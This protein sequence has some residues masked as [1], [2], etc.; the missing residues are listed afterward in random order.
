MPMRINQAL[1]ASVTLVPGPVGAAAPLPQCRLTTGRATYN[2]PALKIPKVSASRLRWLENFGAPK[3]C[4]RSRLHPSLARLDRDRPD[5]ARREKGQAMRYSP[6]GSALLIGA[7]TCGIESLSPA[8]ASS[9]SDWSPSSCWA[10]S[11]D[12]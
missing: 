12:C 2:N 4:P 1:R 7:A 11:S 3:V 9:A 8:K 6:T 5:L 10:S